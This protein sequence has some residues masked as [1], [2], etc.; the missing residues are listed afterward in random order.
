TAIR[1]SESH[2]IASRSTIVDITERRRTEEVLRQA[3]AALETQ[4][5]DRTAELAIANRRLEEQLEESRRTEEALRVSESRF[6]LTADHAPVLIWISDNTKACTWFNKPWLEFVGRR[7]EQEVGNGWVD[8][9][10]PEDVAR[11]VGIYV[12][13]FDTRREFTMEY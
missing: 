6:R 11:C 13:S 5:R 4:V 12:D 9:V 3:H 10:H 7:L 8:N 1:D 2:Y